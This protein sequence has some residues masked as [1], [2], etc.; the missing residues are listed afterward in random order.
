MTSG[1]QG[2]PKIRQPMRNVQTLCGDGYIFW[3]LMERIP[4]KKLAEIQVYV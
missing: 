3:K 1:R 2:A 4:A